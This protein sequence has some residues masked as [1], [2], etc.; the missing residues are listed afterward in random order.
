MGERQDWG[1]DFIVFPQPHGTF[2]AVQLASEVGGTI[3]GAKGAIGGAGGTIVGTKGAI[4]GA[5]GAIVGA[6][7]AIVG[8][9]GAIVGA[10]GATGRAEGSV[11]GFNERGCGT[12]RSP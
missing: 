12:R 9:E 1:K 7:G 3:V 6:E 11:S 8:A 10:E 5:E 4:V 2:I